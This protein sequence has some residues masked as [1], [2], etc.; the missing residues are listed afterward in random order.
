MRHTA[1]STRDCRMI[2][3]FGEETSKFQPTCHGRGHLALGQDIV[4]PEQAVPSADLPSQEILQ[5]ISQLSV[6]LKQAIT[7]Y[8]ILESLCVCRAI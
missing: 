7:E 5:A 4:L 3:W 2:E 6:S 1:D 8:K